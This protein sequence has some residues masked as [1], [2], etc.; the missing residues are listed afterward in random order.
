MQQCYCERVKY[1]Y[2]CNIGGPGA[3]LIKSYKCTNYDNLVEVRT[4]NG[5][6]Y[7]SPLI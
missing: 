4:N 6:C 7:G 1:A 2:F 3:A 5:I